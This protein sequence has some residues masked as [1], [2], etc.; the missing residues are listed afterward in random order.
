M[1]FTHSYFN[2]FDKS[3][4]VSLKDNNVILKNK[5]V[6]KILNIPKSQNNFIKCRLKK[7]A[8]FDYKLE[9]K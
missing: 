3:S 4:H 2:L 6:M 7:N 9:F 8:L 5:T 1:N